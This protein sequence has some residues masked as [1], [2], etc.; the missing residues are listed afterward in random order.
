MGF[1]NVKST[2]SIT[3]FFRFVYSSALATDTSYCPSHLSKSDLYAYG[4]YCLKVH[5]G[6]WDWET[7]RIICIREGG[8]LVQ[9][10]TPGMQEYIRVIL[11]PQKQRSE[12]DGFWIGATDLNMESHWR[13]VSGRAY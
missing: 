7:A 4:D 12:E 3:Y 2:V 11:Q 6:N 10:R 8:D 13:W 5:Y 9:P 1:C